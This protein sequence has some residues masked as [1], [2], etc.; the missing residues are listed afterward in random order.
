V[1]PV[2]T[3]FLISV[4][5]SLFFQTGY[6]QADISFD[7]QNVWGPGR[8]NKVTVRID[9]NKTQGFAR[10]FQEFPVGF[11]IIKDK[12][13]EADFRWENDQLNVV[14]VR[15]PDDPV[16]TFSYYAKPDKSMDGDFMLSG[17]Y[18]CITGRDTRVTKV[19]PEKL[20]VIGGNNGVTA[21]EIKAVT[22]P[23][24]EVKKP[25]KP[26]VTAPGQKNPVIFRV[27]VLISSSDISENELKRKLG[28]D[29]KE[30]VT[31]VRSGKIY[32]YQIGK[33]SGYEDANRYLRQLTANGIKGAFVV[34]YNNEK[35]ITINEAS[36]TS[37]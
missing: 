22:G 13:G 1:N 19:V 3:S 14:W 36:E 4:A 26:L 9:K 37:K 6:S 32:K 21:E 17:K 34:A 20:I 10:F 31:V 18:F 16:I 23:E 25:K 27:Q 24:N 29:L 33:F 12:T 15:L 5:I 28:L 35:Q 11:E 8:Y 2:R 7:C 30:G